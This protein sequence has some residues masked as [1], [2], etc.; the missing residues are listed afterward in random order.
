[1]QKRYSEFRDL[2]KKILAEH[3]KLKERE[4]IPELP[5]WVRL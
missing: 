5:G 4:K 1:V 2:H 3:K